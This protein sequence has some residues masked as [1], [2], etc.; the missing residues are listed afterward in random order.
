MWKV[1][2]DWQTV[3]TENALGREWNVSSGWKCIHLSSTLELESLWVVVFQNQRSKKWNYMI[4][5]CGSNRKWSH[6]YQRLLPKESPPWDGRLLSPSSLSLGRIS[7]FFFPSS[8]SFLSL[9][10][11]LL[12]VPV[13]SL[14][15]P[16]FPTLY[17]Q[18]VDAEA[19]LQKRD[20]SE[21]MVLWELFSV[22]YLIELWE[23]E[24]PTSHVRWSGESDKE[25]PEVRLER[26][27]AVLQRYWSWLLSG[28]PR[29]IHTFTK[30]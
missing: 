19:G 2:H 27:T 28:G 26:H 30:L 1:T 8:S 15:P 16:P 18:L 25:I 29:V 4:I 21:W 5:N 11:F 24:R 14:C 9:F 3:N 10:C 13:S 7:I 20:L 12:P 22:H 6:F 23:E 17:L